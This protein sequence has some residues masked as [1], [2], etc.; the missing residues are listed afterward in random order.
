MVNKLPS[1]RP[2][3]GSDIDAYCSKCDLDLA[4]V[5]IAMV[6]E[7][8][9]RV[10]CKTCRSPHAYRGKQAVDGRSKTAP[11]RMAGK[12]TTRSS[13]SRL[14]EFDRAMQGK[15]LSR[16]QRYK[17]ATTFAIGDVIDH[18]SFRFGVV[19][20]LLSDSKIEVVFEAGPKTLVHARAAG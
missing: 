18:P 5:I 3:A 6:G 8:V 15:D 9:V 2:K 10:Q 19:T 7:R 20:R 14:S 12:T 13:S 11:S 16:A 17:P 4:H 1:T